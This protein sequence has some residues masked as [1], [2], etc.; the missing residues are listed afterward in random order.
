[1][2]QRIFEETEGNPFFLA[3]IVNLMTQEG[4]IEATSLSDITIPDGVREALP[5]AACK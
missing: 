2:L 3:E 1:M 5:A 4:T